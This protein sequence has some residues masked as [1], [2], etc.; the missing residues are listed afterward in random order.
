MPYKSLKIFYKTVPSELQ[1]LVVFMKNYFNNTESFYCIVS[2]EP[3]YYPFLLK[4]KNNFSEGMSPVRNPEL[5]ICINTI[6][7]FNDEDSKKELIF[8]IK[9]RRFIESA[10]LF[11]LDKCVTE[12]WIC[13]IKFGK[14]LKK[15][16]TIDVYFCYI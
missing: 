7:N 9:N 15:M 16:P 1:W 13:K 2:R 8:E 11:A 10:C 5:N 12:K 3:K 6:T 14:N 4:T